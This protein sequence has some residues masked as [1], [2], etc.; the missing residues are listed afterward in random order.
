MQS[1]EEVAVKLVFHEH[2]PRDF[3]VHYPC[4]GE[5]FCVRPSPTAPPKP[6]LTLAIATDLLCTMGGSIF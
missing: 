1:D 5:Q 6:P 3:C 4:L 2:L